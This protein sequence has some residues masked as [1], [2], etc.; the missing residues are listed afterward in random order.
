MTT[1]HNLFESRQSFDLGNGRTG[2]FYS[3][4]ALEKAGL[5][6]TVQ[7][8]RLFRLETGRVDEARADLARMAAAGLPRWIG[9]PL[10]RTRPRVAGQRV[11]LRLVRGR[12]R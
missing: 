8:G 4:P 2:T 12:S 6:L 9:Q 7:D 11:G 1:A 5:G 10:R 3:L